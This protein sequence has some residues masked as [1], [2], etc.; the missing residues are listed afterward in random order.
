MVSN[1]AR[2]HTIVGGMVVVGALVLPRVVGT[3]QSV[4]TEK[5]GVR[6][7]SGQG[8]SP[9]YEGFDLNPDGTYNMWFGYMNLNW[10]EELEIPVG[11]DNGFEGVADRGQ[12]THFATRRHKD[13]FRVIVPKDF[14]TQK[15]VWKLTVRGKTESIGGTLNP[16]WQ[17]DRRRTTRGGNDDAI[18]SNTPPVA[19]I[20]PP[21]QSIAFGAK[22]TL[23]IAATDDGLPKRTRTSFPAPNGAGIPPQLYAVPPSTAPQR[24][25][26]GGRAGG[27]GGR[28]EAGGAEAGSLSYEWFK[29]R[30]PG[31]VTFIEPRGILANGKA[32]SIASF[33]EPGDY[34]L[35]MIVD[36]GSGESAGNFGYHC[37]WT[38]VE[39]KVHV[40]G[41]AP[42]TRR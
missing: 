24:G 8:I 36:D 14:G 29:Y 37:C 7:W 26:A 3:Q 19:S 6:H 39:V 2:C 41:G 25:G 28:G 17:I 18:D 5:M 21:E 31:K 30:G 1:R 38:N 40:T 34:V 10:E 20:Q 32:T 35:Q 42:A 22:A 27:A 23:A 13:V 12:P 9:V 33:S 4:I 11:T 16:V 15:L